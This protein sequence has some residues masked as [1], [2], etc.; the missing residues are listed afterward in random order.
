MQNVNASAASVTT[1]NQM[2]DNFAVQ[3]AT[4]DPH[5]LMPLVGVAH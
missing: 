4:T 3:A 1:A 5:L 2:A